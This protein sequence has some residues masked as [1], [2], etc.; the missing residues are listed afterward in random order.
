M[1]CTIIPV[2]TGIF[3]LIP[4]FF[5]PIDSETRDRM[6]RE[7]AERRKAVAAQMNKEADLINVEAQP[8]A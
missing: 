1:M 2:A 7:L 6:Y 3:G 4:K 8:E 5:Y